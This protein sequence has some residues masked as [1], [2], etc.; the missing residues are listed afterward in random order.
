MV[1]IEKNYINLRSVN[2]FGDSLWYSIK[3]HD[4]K[5]LVN[6]AIHLNYKVNY[7]VYC[8]KVDCRSYAI[9]HMFNKRM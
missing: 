7:K 4:I 5:S 2:C 8:R 6:V 3:F 9:M 1:V